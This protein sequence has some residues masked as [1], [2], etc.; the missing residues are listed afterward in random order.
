M[1]TYF[2]LFLP[3]LPLTLPQTMLMRVKIYVFD[4]LRHD[5]RSNFDK[6]VREERGVIKHSK[7][8]RSSPFVNDCS[9]IK[10]VHLIN[11]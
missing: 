11:F 6:G 7:C 4:K 2:S 10:F 3:I 1:S 8:F 9:F 5:C